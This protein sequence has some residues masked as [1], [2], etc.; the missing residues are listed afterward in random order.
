MCDDVIANHVKVKNFVRAVRFFPWEVDYKSPMS[1][2]KESTKKSM[3]Q[4]KF[5]FSTLATYSL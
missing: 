1:R 4:C 5:L 2:K 3:S